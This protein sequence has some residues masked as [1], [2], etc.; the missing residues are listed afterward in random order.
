MNQSFK[1]PLHLPAF[2]LRVATSCSGRRIVRVGA[3]SAAFFLGGG[4]DAGGQ[5]NPPSPVLL[6]ASTFGRLCFSSPDAALAAQ[7]FL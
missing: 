2:I 3:M 5:I 6:F 7:T 4:G 1:V